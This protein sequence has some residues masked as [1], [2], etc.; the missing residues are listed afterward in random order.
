MIVPTVPQALLLILLGGVFVHFVIAGGRTFYS[1][2]LQN[3]PGA[4]VGQLLFYV[5]GM[6]SIW[7]VGLHQVI[8]WINGIAAAL[9]LALAVAVY[10]WARHSIWLR[11]FGLGWGDHVPDVLCDEGP[12][13]WVRHPI[14]LS[15]LMAF[16]AAFIALPHWLT[17][18]SLLLNVVVFAHGA[19]HDER[20][21]AAS[22]LAEDYAAYRE[23]TGMFLPKLRDSRRT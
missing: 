12:Y 9:L 13:R 11:R 16:L 1:E 3:E 4:L 5:T 6:M 20:R 21:I 2:D 17:A 19:R 7:F 18:V 15:Y 22:P 14:Y 23:R 10:E 8:P